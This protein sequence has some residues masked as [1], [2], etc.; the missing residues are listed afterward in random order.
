MRHIRLVSVMIWLAGSSL[1]LAQ[2]SDSGDPAAAAETLPANPAPSTNETPVPAQNGNGETPLPAPAPLPSPFAPPPGP[3]PLAPTAAPPPPVLAEPAL[4]GFATRFWIGADYLLWWTKGDTL[5]VLVTSGS[6]TDAV[7]GALGQPGTQPL[8]GGN[9][10][11]SVRSGFRLRGGYWFTPDQTFG[12]DATFFF[13]GGQGASF[14]DASDGIPVLARPFYNVNT[15]HED[16]FLVAYPGR[17]SGNIY[18]TL[19]TRL[20]GADTDLRGMLFRGASYQVNVLGGFRFL[21]LHDALGM[22]EN[23]TFF[24]QSTS[25]PMTWSTSADHFYTSNQFYGGQLG[26]DMMWTRGRFFVDVLAKVALGVSVERASINGWTAYNNSLGQSGYLNVGQLAL[27]SNIGCYGQNSFAVVPEFGLNFGYALTPH[28]RLTFGYTF[29]YWSNVF[30]AGDQID[31]GINPT[32]LAALAG[33]GMLTGPAR[34][35]FTMQST[36]FWAQGL[37][38]GLQFRY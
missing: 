21:D 9:H 38:F 22:E 5:P 26:A 11:D 35:N 15:G 16:A 31:T 33:R 37:N 17:E 36:D 10:D 4:D 2:T 27:P 14:S 23:N 25:T 32:E 3:T 18:G 13:L 1:A 6:P 19:S 34:P 8:F 7:P 29:L 28:I 30:R 20:W 12:L 24:P